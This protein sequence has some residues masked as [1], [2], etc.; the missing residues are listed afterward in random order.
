[1]LSQNALYYYSCCIRKEDLT[2]LI[3]TMLWGPD[4]APFST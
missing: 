1:M 4:L 3:T 2:Y